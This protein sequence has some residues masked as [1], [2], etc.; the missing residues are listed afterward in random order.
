MTVIELYNELDTLIREGYSDAP[1]LIPSPTGGDMEV[2]ELDT[3]GLMEVH[4]V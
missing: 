1:A 3:K 4:L 2:T